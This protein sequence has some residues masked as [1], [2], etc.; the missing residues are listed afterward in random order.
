[1][2]WEWIISIGIFIAG[3]A[4]G[5]MWCYWREDVHKLEK[6]VDIL[7][8]F[9]RGKVSYKEAAEEISRINKHKDP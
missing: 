7:D 6:M 5:Y 1:M 2:I 3:L 8:K 9:F 4:C